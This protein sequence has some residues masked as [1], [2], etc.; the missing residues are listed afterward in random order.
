MELCSDKQF[1]ERKGVLEIWDRVES[2]QREGRRRHKEPYMEGG[3]SS[4]FKQ[5]CGG[6]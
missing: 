5:L 1:P 2:G 4:L 3:K 6:S